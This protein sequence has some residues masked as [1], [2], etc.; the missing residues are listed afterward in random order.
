MQANFKTAA[1]AA[2]MLALSAL[3]FYASA[4]DGQCAPLHKTK[5]GEDYSAST[6]AHR[7]SERNIGSVGISIYPGSD[8]KKMELPQ[9][10]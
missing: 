2:T 1:A 4:A 5:W 6:S 9:I 10:N 7:Y 8:L 3:P